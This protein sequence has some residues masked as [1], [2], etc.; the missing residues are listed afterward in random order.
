[1]FDW[2]FGASK[3][4]EKVVDTGCGLLTTAASGI[5]MMFYTDEEKAQA[6]AAVYTQ[7]LK[8]QEVIREEGSV[9]SVT[10]RMIAV[11][12]TTIFL[13]MCI[14]GVVLAL[15]TKDPSNPCFDMVS[16]MGMIEMTIIVFYF[17]PTMIGR[18]ITSVK[19]EK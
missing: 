1:M 2:L 15:I 8:T 19:K 11:A 10:R 18:A 3:S 12:F 16:E 14:A 4:A 9:R 6:K 17:G 7:W 13:C 5:D